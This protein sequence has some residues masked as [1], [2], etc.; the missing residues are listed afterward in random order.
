MNDIDSFLKEKSWAGL[1]EKKINIVKTLPPNTIEF[2][3]VFSERFPKLTKLLKSARITDFQICTKFV[4]DQPSKAE[5]F[6]SDE[7]IYRLWAWTTHSGKFAAWSTS[8]ISS[9]AEPELTLISDDHRQI[10]RHVGGINWGGCCQSENEGL[11]QENKNFALNQNFIF[12]C[13]SPADTKLWVESYIYDYQNHDSGTTISPYV[14]FSAPEWVCFAQEANGNELLY[15]RRKNDRV[16]LVAGDHCFDYAYPSRDYQ[17]RYKSGDYQQ[18]T[19][20]EVE[21]VISLR[22]WAEKLAAQWLSHIA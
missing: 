1:G 6:P 12:G 13:E 10:L 5:I 16:L 9:I 8:P 18:D 7:V 11:D 21:G 15:D 20:L 17:W 4:D 2:D 22:D 14:N 3:P 19:L